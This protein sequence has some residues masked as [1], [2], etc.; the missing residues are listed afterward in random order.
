M[1]HLCLLHEVGLVFGV[2]DPEL[3]WPEY[4][5]VVFGGLDCFRELVARIYS[6][7]GAPEKL[8]KSSAQR[9]RVR[10]LRGTRRGGKSEPLQGLGDDTAATH[11]IL[12]FPSTCAV[13]LPFR[14][15]TLNRFSEG[16]ESYI[17]RSVGT[18]FG[19]RR[20]T[21]A[22]K[23]HR[24]PS[25]CLHSSQRYRREN[26]RGGSFAAAEVDLTERLAEGS[27]LGVFGE[28]QVVEEEVD[29]GARKFRMRLV[30]KS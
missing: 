11:S 6:L 14:F 20:S 24:R 26:K 25:R 5:E 7:A 9:R 2:L 23:T 18:S 3:G 4:V 28:L 13:V 22:A 30:C 17:T 19:A 8:K 10:G 1:E 16:H 29:E 21:T 12:N 15:E 27:I